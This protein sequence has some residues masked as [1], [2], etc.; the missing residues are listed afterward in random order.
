MPSIQEIDKNFQVKTF[1]TREN[2]V[3]LDVTQPPFT[4]HGLIPPQQADG[5]FR[6]MSAQVAATVSEG[7]DALHAN[8]AGGRIR[9][10]TDSAYIAVVAQMGAVGKMPHFALTG[11]AGFDLY[12]G[13][14]HV[15]S[16]QPQFD[17]QDRLFGEIY[18]SAHKMTT[19]TLHFPLYSD[20]RS[21]H[22]LLD[23]DA[24]IA[25]PDPY[26]P[27]APILF[28]GSSIT[29][30]GCASRPGNCY[31]AIMARRMNRDIWNLGF[32]GSAKGEPEMAAYI[33]GLSMSALVYD[34][35]YNAPTAEH[36][37]KTHL[38]FLQTVRKAHPDI[39]ILCL[40]RPFCRFPDAERRNG[41]IQRSVEILQNS[42]D[43]NI[44]FFDIYRYLKDLGIANEATVD[45][46][47]PNDLGF[48]YMAQAV[49]E[50]LAPMWK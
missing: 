4:L 41:I 42:G 17:I 21:V 47:H 27:E 24:Q 49:Q 36:L 10:Q 31:S 33:A 11:S 14:T 43:A 22:I 45:C 19:Y 46:V 37:E 20:V 2:T 48:Y 16:F 34:Y 30:G 3:A 15:G 32:S 28:Y 12:D 6:R 29:Q 8:C 5:L 9:F 18:L 7:V 39:P 1:T 50:A 26:G 25:P 38:P 35:D 40:N 44:A 23:A 13:L